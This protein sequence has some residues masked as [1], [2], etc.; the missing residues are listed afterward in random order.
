MRRKKGVPRPNGGDGNGDDDDD[1]DDDVS[2]PRHHWVTLVESI[3]AIC[4]RMD[5]T[6]WYTVPRRNRK[7]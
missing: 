2:Y 6:M 5:N 1:N 7:Q 4:V 3:L